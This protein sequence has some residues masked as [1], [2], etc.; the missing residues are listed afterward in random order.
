MTASAQVMRFRLSYADC[1]PAQ[2]VYLA[3]YYPWFERTSTE[4]W[5]SQGI[6]IDE[7][8]ATHGVALVSR[9][10]GCEYLARTRVLDLLDCRMRVS[11]IGR[12]SATFAF[13]V[14]RVDDSVT[15]AKGFNTLVTLT[16]EAG[17][18]I[19]IPPALRQILVPAAVG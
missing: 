11:R 7:L 12:S 18:V 5:L 2:V 1:D 19:P 3:A 4:W 6:R 16:P 14:V 13:E 15:V 9:A 10:S 17:A 8:P